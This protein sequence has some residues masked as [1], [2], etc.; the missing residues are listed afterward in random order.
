[1]TNDNE[2]NRDNI[3]RDFLLDFYWRKAYFWCFQSDDFFSL[4]QDNELNQDNIY[5]G[6]QSD[7]FF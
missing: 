4:N 1:M 5:R 2:L 7:D 3:Y 6:F